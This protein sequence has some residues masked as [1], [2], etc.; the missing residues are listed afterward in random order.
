M[1]SVLFF[2]GGKA[3]NLFGDP[4]PCNHDGL[5]G[6]FDGVFS[7]LVVSSTFCPRDFLDFGLPESFDVPVSIG[8]KSFVFF[9]GGGRTTSSSLSYRPP[10]SY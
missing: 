9:F 2:F 5:F 7:F 4:W 3:E 1:G 10:P 6:N 8:V